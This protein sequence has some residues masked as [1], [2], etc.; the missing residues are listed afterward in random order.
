MSGPD[1]VHSHDFGHHLQFRSA[2]GNNTERMMEIMTRKKSQL[3]KELKTERKGFAETSHK[4]NWRARSGRSRRIC[5][6]SEVMPPPS[7]MALPRRVISAIGERG[8]GEAGGSALDRKRC[9]QG[10]EE[11]A[12]R[13]LL[14]LSRKEYKF[15]SQFRQLGS[16]N[17]DAQELAAFRSFTRRT[18]A[19]TLAR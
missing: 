13:A 16:D 15:N 9:R 10:R 4:C 5:V 7:A 3:E 17:G 18:Q 19:T 14:R 8:Q 2:F 12:P 11:L 6:G 1:F